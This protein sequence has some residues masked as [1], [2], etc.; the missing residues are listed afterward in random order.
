MKTLMMAVALL[1]ISLSSSAARKTLLSPYQKLKSLGT[2]FSLEVKLE[3][4]RYLPFRKDISNHKVTFYYKDGSEIKEL[5]SDITNKEGN[6]SIHLPGALVTGN[7]NFYA[8]FSGSRKYKKSH[9]DI[10]ITVVDPS[11]KVVLTDIDKTISDAS[12]A[13]VLLKPNHKIPALPNSVKLVNELAKTYQIVYLTA[14]DDVFKQKTFAWLK[15]K[16]F[17]VGPTYFWDSNSD[18]LPRDHGEFKALVIKRIMKEI[19]NI[20]FAAGDKPHDVW[21]YRENGIRSYYIGEQDEEIVPFAIRVTSWD[22]IMEHFSTF[23]LGT[24]E[25]DP[26]F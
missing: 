11:R 25:G 10:L 19:P 8:K 16:K 22:Q 21:A 1:S 23:P 13:A 17:P 24:V 18:D 20:V 5:G 3:E 7:F 26:I 14:R 6:A 15:Q 4:A 2:E 9:T 12:G